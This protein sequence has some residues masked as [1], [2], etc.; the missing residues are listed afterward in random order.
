MAL[1]PTASQT[2]GPFFALGLTWT[3]GA[4]LAGPNTP[5]RRVV[6]EGRVLDGDRQP[7][8]DAMVE[9]WQANAAGRY[10]HPEDRQNKPLDPG[11]TGFGRAGVDAAGRFRFT[12]VKPGAVP[13][14]AGGL[15]AP[16][17]LVGVFAR[18]LLKR[19]V[20]RLYFADEP[21]NARDPVLA[22][23]PA[24]R[25]RTLMAVADPAAPDRYRFDIVLQGEG[26]T[27]FFDC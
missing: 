26:E 15:Q 10:A 23:V 9:I 25:R 19:L 3:D 7:V 11:F 2:V 6:I 13:A 12:T 21:A 4:A 17:I 5:G 20:T 18:G 1:P 14:P 16:H 8:P 27:V 24:T 22:L